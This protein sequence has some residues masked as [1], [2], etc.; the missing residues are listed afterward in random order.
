[1]SLS[2]LRATR[3]TFTVTLNQ[4][5]KG[6]LK[7]T[8]DLPNDLILLLVTRIK[9]RYRKVKYQQSRKEKEETKI[10]SMQQFHLPEFCS[11]K[12]HPYALKHILCHCLQRVICVLPLSHQLSLHGWLVDA[13]VTVIRGTQERGSRNCNWRWRVSDF[14]TV[15]D[16][17]QRVTANAR[18]WRH[19]NCIMQQSNIEDEG[20]KRRKEM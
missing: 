9:N 15:T 2:G 11:K 7:D 5:R 14:S 19:N 12:K 20:R 13:S 6:Q 18:E 1:M 4:R 10:A 8:I 17:R 16:E 3:E